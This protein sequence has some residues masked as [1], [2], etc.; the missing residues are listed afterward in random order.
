MVTIVYVSGLFCLFYG[1]RLF[2]QTKSLDYA[3][4]MKEAINGCA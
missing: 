4:K 2:I 1:S 3:V